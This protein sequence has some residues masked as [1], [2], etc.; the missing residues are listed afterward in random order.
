MEWLPGTLFFVEPQT[1][2]IPN[3]ILL[4]IR[5]VVMGDLF[6]E[7]KYEFL[8]TFNGVSYLTC[9]DA[10]HLW[11]SKK[12]VSFINVGESYPVRLS[13]YARF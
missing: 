7:N 1:E 11:I 9:Y 12:N 6:V 2:D 3:M 5:R 8:E 13:D 10:P 4:L